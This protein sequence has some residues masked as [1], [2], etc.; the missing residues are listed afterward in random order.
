MIV[1]FFI[2]QLFVYKVDKV[3]RNS[4]NRYR[5]PA[6]RPEMYKNDICDD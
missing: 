1:A 6:V 4:K 5:V 3:K 2:E